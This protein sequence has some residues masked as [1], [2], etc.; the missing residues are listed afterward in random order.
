MGLTVLLTACGGCDHEEV[1]DPAVAATCTADGLTEGK[2]C[3]KCNEVLTAQ[4]TVPATGHTEVTDAAVEATC[5][6]SGK[7]EGKHCSA[8]GEVFVAQETVAALGH[9]TEV[10][11]CDR[12]GA[13]LGKWMTNYYVDDFQ[14]PT[15]EGYVTNIDYIV[16]TFSNSATTNSNLYVQ[17]LADAEDIAFVLYE[18]GRNIVK[19]N[20]SRY[21][22][23]YSIAMRMPDGSTKDM[24]GTLYCGGDRVYVDDNYKGAVISAL[25]GEG[26]ISFLI[27]DQEYTTSQYLFTVSASNF[28]LEYGALS[29]G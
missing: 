24:T 29:N 5:L 21:V 23:E 26:D 22:D 17:V 3:S 20:S 10:G 19:N 27:V 6:S 14:Q 7:T 9:T 12:C 16:G 2:H 25:S 18:Y 4:E 11:T 13:N 28:G 1:T 15:N 8:C